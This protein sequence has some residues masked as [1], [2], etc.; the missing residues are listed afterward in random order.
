MVYHLHGPDATSDYSIGRMLGLV[1]FDWL[2]A[3][4]NAVPA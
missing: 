3:A 4:L 2:M 1:A